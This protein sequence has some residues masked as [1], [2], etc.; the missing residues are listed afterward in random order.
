MQVDRVQKEFKPLLSR[1]P[2]KQILGPPKKLALFR[3]HVSN[4]GSG[5]ILE[6]FSIIAEPFTNQRPTLYK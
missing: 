4:M 2:I 3:N 5:I 6:K 1:F